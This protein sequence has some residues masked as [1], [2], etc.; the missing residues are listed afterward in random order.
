M[1]QRLY[2]RF[3]CFKPQD[4]TEDDIKDIENA[5]EA[6]L[7]RKFVVEPKR[8]LT[9][10]SPDGCRE[11]LRRKR[12]AREIYGH[13]WFWPEDWYEEIGEEGEYEFSDIEL[14]NMMIEECCDEYGSIDAFW[15]CNGI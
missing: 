13:P 6:E 11:Y 7:E 3:R 12:V 9:H 2:T 14:T 1:R 10:I 15:E 5:L 4:L 8:K